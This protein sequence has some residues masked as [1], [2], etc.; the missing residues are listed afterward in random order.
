MIV[1]LIGVAIGV[2]G[3]IAAWYSWT[4]ESPR[5]R[6]NRESELAD[7]IVKLGEIFEVKTSK[8]ADMTLTKLLSWQKEHPGELA[9][10]SVRQQIAYVSTVSVEAETDLENIYKTIPSSPKTALLMLSSSIERAMRRLLASSGW[11]QNEKSVTIP[12]AFDRLTSMGVFSLGIASSVPL[13]WKVHESMATASKD[14][15][16]RGIDAGITVLKAINAVPLEKNVV[17]H[18]GVAVFVD[19]ACK[20]SIPGSTQNSE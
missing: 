20:Q 16:I 4:H 6:R 3:L 5:L 13:F 10:E 18:P 8:M 7:L 1:G 17:Y 9:T 11:L 12:D 14:E 19:E 15:I 2:I